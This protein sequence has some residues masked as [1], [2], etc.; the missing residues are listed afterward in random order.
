MVSNVS[1]ML[2]AITYTSGLFVWDLN[3]HDLVFKKEIKSEKE[4]D[5]FFECFYFK[6]RRDE[7]PL[8]TSC[9][10]DK[11]G[12]IKI[13]Q[14]EE[15]LAEVNKS[16]LEEEN[17]NEM[18]NR[19]MHRDIIRGSYWNDETSHLYTVGDD[20]FLIKWSLCEKL[21][22]NNEKRAH[23][24]RERR[25]DEMSQEDVDG[26]DFKKNKKKFLK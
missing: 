14:N 19:R 20:G 12:D 1:D 13:I 6:S 2:Y 9:M 16:N 10:A 18:L 8:L 15:I 7:L 17:P 23:T 4:E 21:N 5:Y 11:R 3:T 22:Q 26:V 24:K 25:D